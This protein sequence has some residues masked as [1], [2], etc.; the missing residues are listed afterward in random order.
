MPEIPESHRDL[1]DAAAGALATIG[2]DGYPQVTMAW[3]V[4][5]D[6]R[7][8]LSLNTARTKTQNLLARPQCSFLILD[9]A[10]PYRYVEIRARA[11]IEPDDDYEL[12]DI[13]GA[14][15][16]ADPKTLDGPG[17]RRVA[18]T[19]EPVFV[20]AWPAEGH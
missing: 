1:L 19:L 3:F 12:A 6:G 4:H 18:V 7:I 9:P 10:T 17:E 20:W 5:H 11:V 2:G 13:L 16:D 15:Y 14:K 8:R